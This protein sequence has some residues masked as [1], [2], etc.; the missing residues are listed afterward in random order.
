MLHRLTLR[1]VP[2]VRITL[3]DL[4]LSKFTLYADMGE[5][6]S[7]PFMG[8][9]G[10]LFPKAQF[11]IT[12]NLFT[13]GPDLYM[14]MVLTRCTFIRCSWPQVKW[15]V[16]CTSISMLPILLVSYC[17]AFVNSARPERVSP[18]RDGQGCVMF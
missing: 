5:G 1:E 18:Y 13:H 7:I 12:G 8:M 4:E 6:G 17:F 11:M 3:Q 15:Y 2:A 9:L 10:A 16:N 14:F